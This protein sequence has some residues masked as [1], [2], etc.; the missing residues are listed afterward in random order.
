MTQLDIL[1]KYS[2]EFEEIY[3]KNVTFYLINEE[4]VVKMT[5]GWVVTKD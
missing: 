2:M 5:Q 3:N 1:L 4:S